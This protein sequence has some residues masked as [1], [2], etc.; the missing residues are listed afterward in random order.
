MIER[1]H[2]SSAKVAAGKQGSVTGFMGA[3]TYSLSRSA[4][5]NLEFQTLFYALARL[6]PFCG[7]GHKTTFGLGE[8]WLGWQEAE[9]SITVPA[10]QQIL[11]ERIEELTDLFLSQKKRQGGS[12]AQ[13]TAQ[14]WATILARR[15]QGDSLAAIA[16]DMDIPYETAKTYSKLARKALKDSEAN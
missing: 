16:S 13:D 14:K 6:A 5:D 1:H 7:T 12:R 3:V 11:A 9:N 4:A 8:T 2:L 10:L 15:E